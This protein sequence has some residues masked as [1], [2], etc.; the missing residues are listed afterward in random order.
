MN[1]ITIMDGVRVRLQIWFVK[2][3]FGECPPYFNALQKS[4]GVLEVF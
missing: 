4:Q 1:V 3:A 2:L